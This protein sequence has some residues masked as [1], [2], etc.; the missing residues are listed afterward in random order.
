[1][2]N[3][4]YEVVRQ[5]SQCYTSTCAGASPSTNPHSVTTVVHTVSHKSSGDRKSIVGRVMICAEHQ[6]FEWTREEQTQPNA[7]KLMAH[8][9][10][11]KS[12]CTG[13]L[14]LQQL[15]HSMPEGACSSTC[16]A[17]SQHQQNGMP[18]ASTALAAWKRKT[19]TTTCC[20]TARYDAYHA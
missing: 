11:W 14:Q 19:H 7:T 3:I 10:C 9:R 15:Y 17:C 16:Y 1:M 5:P 2:K 12:Y 6:G 18:A 8:T 4:S 20:T 13:K